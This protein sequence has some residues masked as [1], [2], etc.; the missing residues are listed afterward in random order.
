MSNNYFK[1]IFFLLILLFIPNIINAD[2]CSTARGDAAK[3]I[4]S[5]EFMYR[6]GMPTFKITLKNMT[7]NI[8]AESTTSSGSN[9][10]MYVG[11]ML[12]P[13]SIDI[14]IYDSNYTCTSPARVIT[15]NLPQ[16][17][18][19][20]NMDICKDIKSYKYCA[21]VLTEKIEISDIYT[22]LVNYKKSLIKNDKIE[23][24]EEKVE[25]QFE[26]SDDAPVYETSKRPETKELKANSEN[27]NEDENENKITFILCGV[28]AILLITA[29]I[30][31]IIYKR[32]KKKMVI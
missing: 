9:R 22:K 15:V 10:V 31:I 27:E 24:D 28:V 11:A 3:V 7:K 19:Y 2:V 30:I 18:Q 17:N 8:A 13:Y 6:D 16:Y 20:S 4:A 26:I 14:P 21:E 25:E 29:V 12:D 23:G 1:Y 32:K 5:Y